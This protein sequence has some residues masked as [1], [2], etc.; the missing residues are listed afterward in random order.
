M[1]PFRRVLKGFDLT[2]PAHVHDL[3]PSFWNR[4]TDT[5]NLGAQ[6]IFSQPSPVETAFAK[7]PVRTAVSYLCK[8]VA[9]F[10]HAL[11]PRKR[12]Y[13]WEFVGGWE[14]LLHFKLSEP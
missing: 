1:T 6:V 9:H 13:R 10:E 4:V 12:D 8:A 2:Y 11:V 3:G 14:V 7:A 5:F